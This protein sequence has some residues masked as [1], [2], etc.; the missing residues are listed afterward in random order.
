[1]SATDRILEHNREFARSF[2]PGDLT[3]RPTRGLAVLACMDARLDVARCLGLD[4]GEAHIIRNAGGL[5]TEDALRSLMLSQRL[6]GTR[7][8][9][10]IQHTRCG[11]QD[12]RDDEVLDAVAV[13]SGVRPEFRL[14]GFDD[15]EANVRESVRT[16]RACPFLPHRD[17]VRGFVYDVDEGL[18]KEVV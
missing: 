5:A 4:L 11:L 8:I 1:M 9:A 12:L 7:E 16:L 14:G 18:L 10:V 13:E 6:L 17:G 3:A 15:L 2:A